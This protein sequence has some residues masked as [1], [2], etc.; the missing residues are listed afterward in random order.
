MDEHLVDG[1]VSDF[2]ARRRLPVA[3][4]QHAA[5][6]PDGEDRRA[7]WEAVD[8]HAARPGGD[9]WRR[10]CRAEAVRQE[11]RVAVTQKADEVGLY[12]VG[13]LGA[14]FSSE[15]N[16]ALSPRSSATENTA[17]PKQPSNEGHSPPR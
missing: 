14:R 5:F 12:G 7:V 6:E 3:S 17:H 13:I 4:D 1:A 9:R 10:G 11:T 8:V 15:Q 2:V 16:A